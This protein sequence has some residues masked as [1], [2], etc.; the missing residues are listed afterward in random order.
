VMEE[1][2]HGK[3][4]EKA[5]EPVLPS[6]DLFPY[7]IRVVSEALSSNGSTSQGSICAS[8][9]ALMDGGVPIKR[10]VAG[11]A[12]GLGYRNEKEYAVLTD[13]QG[14]EDHH[15]GMDFKVAGTRK[16]ITA[17]QMD[18]K[19]SGIPFHILREAFDRGV[20]ARTQILDVIEKEIQT[21]RET[22]HKNAP[23]IQMIQIKPD[24]IGLVIGSGGKT[25][26]ETKD[27]AGVEIDIE[28]DGRV[29]ITGSQQGVEQ[30]RKI[31]EAQTKE[32]VKGERIQGKVIKVVEFGAFV[33]LDESNEALLHV[34]EIAPF[35]I[36]KVE[37]YLKVGD[38]IPVVVKQIDDQ[39]RIK[40]S[41]KDV[42]P[43][44]IKPKK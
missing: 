16:G 22:L 42:D 11:I 33:K 39:G 43:N 12:I 25:I 18:V 26:K 5:L 41:L 3:L 13:I 32:Y 4:A 40:L 30:A 34:S 44:F 35:R 15:G 10:P 27:K 29:F 2:G 38:T 20:A 36:E 31:I 23:H 19:L 21:P 8:S 14:P 17:V 9:I 37:D 1:L 6:R 24:Q 7:T 28:D